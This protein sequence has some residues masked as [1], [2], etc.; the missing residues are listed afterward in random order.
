[1]IAQR[2]GIKAQLVDGL[3]N[4][5]ALVKGVEQGALELVARVQP[6]AVVVLGPQFVNGVLDARVSAVATPRWIPAIRTRGGVLIKMSVDVIDMEEGCGLLARTGI[7]HHLLIST[8]WTHT[9]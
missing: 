6:Q 9:Y 4:L 5:L 2:H 7:W 8:A 3:G 1:V